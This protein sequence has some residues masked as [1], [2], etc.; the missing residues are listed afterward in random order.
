[1]QMKG[2]F[3][4]IILPLCLAAPG[5]E[6]EVFRAPGNPLPLTFSLPAGRGRPDG[7]FRVFAGPVEL[8][9]QSRVLARYPDGAARFYQLTVPAAGE[10]GLTVTAGRSAVASRHPVSLSRT[11]DR[12]TATNSLLTLT[13]ETAPLALVLER[14]SARAVLAAPRLT[15][16]DGTRPA[17]GPAKLEVLE[18]GPLKSHLRLRGDFALPADRN[19]ARY[20]E[21]NLVFFADTGIVGVELVYGVAKTRAVPKPVDEM[22]LTASLE[23]PIEFDRRGPV[24]CFLRDRPAPCPLADGQRAVQWEFDRCE[25]NGVEEAGQLAGV[26]RQ[27]DFL[28]SVPE[29]PERFPAGVRRDGAQLVL[30]LMP[31]ITRPGRYR[32]RDAEYIQYFYLTKDAYELRSG[33]EQSFRFFLGFA[34]GD[35]R[36]TGLALQT[37]NVG[38]P[39]VADFNSAGAWPQKITP[40]SELTAPYDR[41]LGIAIANY[42]KLR[43]DERWYGMLNYGDWHGERKLN[44]G[45]HEYDT[46][47][48]FF[49]HA[50]RFR[51]PEL[52]REALRGARHLI[53][54][55]TVHRHAKPQLVGGVWEHA[56]GHTGGYYERESCRFEPHDSNSSPGAGAATDAA[57]RWPVRLFCDSRLV[58]GHTRLRGIALAYLLSGDRRFFDNAM[59]SARYLMQNRMFARRSWTGTHREPGW[60]LFN[61]ASVYLIEPDPAIL[62]ALQKLGEIVIEQAGDRGV[63]LD[64]L[65][66][67]NA[68]PKPGG[69]TAAEEALRRGALSFP[70]GYQYIGMAELYKLT[71]DPA[72]RRNLDQTAAYVR[73]RLYRPETEGFVHSPVPWRRQSRR[74][75]GTAAI[76]SLVMLHNYTLEKNR[77]SLDI[78]RK[79]TRKQLA[80][81]ELFVAVEKNEDPETPGPKEFT[82]GAYFFPQLWELLPPA[83]GNAASARES[84]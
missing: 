16:P 31:A 10:A 4:A 11:G 38:L 27:N 73:E 53:D 26:F 5:A 28:L 2:L 56:L 46:P 39:A 65:D 49:E 19:E 8:P 62:A 44:W 80:K 50:I 45:N 14:N 84:R 72:V 20:Y 23:L 59:N 29:M 36:Q 75:G 1:M 67:R 68:P 12:L 35:L 51:D 81:S 79:T 13:V 15:L 33:L 82:S 71:A 78:F 77:D 7:A 83:S 74:T 32:D 70:T 25:I 21:Y 43:A 41:E 57:G 66:A 34:D 69:M 3:F 42:F 24:G 47:A 55:D 6:I 54:V 37:E 60:T 40:P 76:L 22:T 30:E 61:L 52:F 64:K 63:R 48:I 18:H 17:A 9:V 58:P